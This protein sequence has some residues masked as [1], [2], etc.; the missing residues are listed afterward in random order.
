[1][2]IGYIVDV[3]TSV[4]IQEIVENAGNVIEVFAGVFY[5]EI[6]KLSPFR[7]TIEKLFASRQNYK[8]E[9]NDLLQGLVKLIMNSLYG[10]QIRKD[11]NQFYKC[12]SEHW[13]QTEY[14]GNVLD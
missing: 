13:M 10:V 4:D 8:D 9:R 6:F 1:M 5:C 2:R 11:N 3:L 12:K 14:D 7:K